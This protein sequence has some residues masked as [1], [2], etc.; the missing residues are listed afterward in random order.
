MF[1]R[2]GGDYL[3]GGVGGLCRVAV[4]CVGLQEAEGRVMMSPA[5]PDSSLH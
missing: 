2:Q 5:I 4:P 3:R 1:V